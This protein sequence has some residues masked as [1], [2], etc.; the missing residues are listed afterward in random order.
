MDFRADK[1]NKEGKEQTAV[2]LTPTD[3][4]LKISGPAGKIENVPYSQL[5][6]VP[7]GYLSKMVI[8]RVVPTEHTIISS[9]FNLLKMLLQASSGKLQEQIKQRLAE[10]KRD[11]TRVLG[12]WTA[13]A[14]S[15]VALLCAGYFATDLSVDWAMKTIPADTE[16][17]IGDLL[18]KS[19][20]ANH[21][22]IL[23]NEQTARLRK[24]GAQL[25]TH[26]PHCPYDLTFHVE[27]NGAVN[28]FALPGGT[29]VVYS[30]LLDSATTDDELAGVMAHEIGHIIK[31]HSLRAMLHEAGTGFCLTLVFK[32]HGPYVH[33]ALKQ[34]FHLDQLRF[35]RSQEQQ[36][37]EVGVRLSN[38]A[39]YDPHGL[40][41]FFKK[42]EKNEGPQISDIF[43][44]HPMTSERV[45]N[46]ERLIKE[47]PGQSQR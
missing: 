32:G 43:S 36:A 19:Y 9:D 21:K 10:Y 14:V 20:A 28:A 34:A 37:D 1:C 18:Y 31:R 22:I 2:L 11:R 7:V 3:S 26:L 33:Q 45:K 25:V 16:S 44:T 47:L 17:T 24:V 41:I 42:L 8:L 13:V 27:A 15:L 4:G 23:D 29:I 30:G 12:G 6:L 38:A 5:E 39:G 46:I 40:I 35:S